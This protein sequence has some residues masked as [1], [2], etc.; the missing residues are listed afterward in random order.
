MYYIWKLNFRESF[1]NV[2]S[3]QIPNTSFLQNINAT[4]VEKWKQFQIK[5][6]FIKLK[7][8]TIKKVKYMLTICEINYVQIN[9]KYN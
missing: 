1:G 9:F 5:I 7:N 3:Q 2:G 8:R 6:I 4:I